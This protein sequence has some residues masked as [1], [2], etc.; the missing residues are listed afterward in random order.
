MPLAHKYG[1]QTVTLDRADYARTKVTYSA[2]PSDRHY[3]L[4]WLELAAMYEV[5]RVQAAG[6]CLGEILGGTRRGHKL[7]RPMHADG[8]M[9]SCCG[10]AIHRAMGVPSNIPISS[11][12]ALVV[13]A[14]LSSL[15]SCASSYLCNMRDW[16]TFVYT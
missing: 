1:F 13:P 5:C 2:N 3:A 14:L 8:P 15:E 7:G 9:D 10:C 12:P 4:K 6:R 16:L 11:Y